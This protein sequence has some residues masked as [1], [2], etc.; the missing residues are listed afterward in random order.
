MLSA[1]GLKVVVIAGACLGALWGFNAYSEHQQDI[2]YNRAN[3]EHERLNLQREA[4][5]AR[6]ETLQNKQVLEAESNATKREQALRDVVAASNVSAGKLRNTLDAISR[7]SGTATAE[8]LRTTNATL[9][10][11]FADC[12]A[13]YR[14]MGQAADGHASD[15]RTLI[16]AWP[17]PPAAPS[18]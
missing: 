14:E 4:L 10:T 17:A 5:T 18:K 3:Q 2:G 7:S 13:R 12:T 15:V 9:T 1:T 6:L 16:E 11:V 8:A